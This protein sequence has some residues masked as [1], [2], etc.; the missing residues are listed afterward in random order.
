MSI[1]FVTHSLVDKNPLGAG[2]DTVAGPVRDQIAVILC[3]HTATDNG[4]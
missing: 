3:V 4:R 1:T 2:G